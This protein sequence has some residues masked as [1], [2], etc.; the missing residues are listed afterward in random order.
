MIKSNV[1]ELNILKQKYEKAKK[2]VNY[3]EELRLKKN[4]YDTEEFP[5]H[6]LKL[7]RVLILDTNLVVDYGD[8][9]IDRVVN[10][11]FF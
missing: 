7:S 10:G 2:R 5:K 6:L 9:F 3:L 8:S 11:H 1:D 4:D